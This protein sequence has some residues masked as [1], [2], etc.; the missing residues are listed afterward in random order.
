MDQIKGVR[1]EVIKLANQ[2]QML[3]GTATTLEISLGAGAGMEAREAGR[4]EEYDRR[5]AHLLEQHGEDLNGV[6]P[7]LAM[8]AMESR[9]A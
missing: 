3:D 8:R 4:S 5:M 9:S 1:K 7:S 6:D 2:K